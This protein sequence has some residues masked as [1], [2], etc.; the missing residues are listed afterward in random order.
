VVFSDTHGFRSRNRNGL[1]ASQ[2]KPREGDPAE[3]KPEKAREKGK[4]H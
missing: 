1:T 3:R 4:I 2:D